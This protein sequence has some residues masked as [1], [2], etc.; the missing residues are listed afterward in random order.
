[1]MRQYELVDRVRAYDSRADEDLLNRAYVYAM[2]MHG[3]QKRASGDLYFTHPIAVAGILAGLRLD[4]ATIATALLH[5]TLEDT[6][7]KLD[8]I[9][10]LFGSE[11]A[12]LV[13]GVTKL[14]NLE[15]I[16]HDTVQA[17]NFR[18]LLLATADDVRVLLVKLAD[19]LHNM[20]TL[21]HIK[22]AD[23]RRRIARETM[24][25]YA[26]LAARMGMQDVREEL[27]DLAF[28]TLNP[29]ARDTILARLESVLKKGTRKSVSNIEKKLCQELAKYDIEADV[30]SRTKKPYAIWRKIE[31]H[32]IALEQLSDLIGFRIIASSGEACYRALFAVHHA[33]KY[34]PGSFRDYISTPKLNGYRSL[35]TQII[36]PEGRRVEIQVRTEAMHEEAELG[37]AAHWR[38]KESKP[39]RPNGQD[40]LG[41]FAWLRRVVDMVKQGDDPREFLEHTKMELF[42]DQVFCFTVGG[43]LIALPRGA[44]PIDFAYEIHTD[45]GNS[46]AGAKVNGRPHPLTTPLRNGDEVEIICSTARRPP[47]A[48]AS[49]VITAKARLA[50]RRALRSKKRE[51]HIK[52]GRELLTSFLRRLRSRLDAKALSRALVPLKQASVDDLLAEIGCGN[53]PARQVVE[54]IYP[55]LRAEA[56][57]KA[58]GKKGGLALSI[59]GIADDAPVHFAAGTFLLP[60]DKIVG[61]LTHGRGVTIYPADSP[62]LANF[63]DEP[64]RWIDLV[65]DTKDRADSYIGRIEVEMADEVGALASVSA[66]IAKQKS[67]IHNLKLVRMNPDTR[68]LHIDLELRHVTHMAALLKALCALSC[69]HDAHRLQHG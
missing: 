48:W 16:S 7:A 15:L 27:E 20:R 38:Y 42:Q 8:D 36:G 68:V 34:I 53:I 67:N 5:D 57:K 61:I 39:A 41:P 19:R 25:I 10:T 69:V 62:M 59:H 58:E 26:P 17:E 55:R 9:N 32:S 4:S 46:C 63:E 2:K 49:V 29:R 30:H 44:T 50:I 6:G 51:G 37:I 45:I 47:A 43:R 13:D 23:K 14:A 3:K 24:D 54:I 31:R 28:R 52:I 60:G 40:L 64:E 65:W 66:L 18:K 56:R 1:M 22:S 11:V 21:D 12:H 33:W 35:H